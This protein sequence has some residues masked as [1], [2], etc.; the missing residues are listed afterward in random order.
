MAT[1]TYCM[2]SE[3]A[4]DSILLRPIGTASPRQ[5]EEVRSTMLSN[6]R[7]LYMTFT[8]ANFKET[9]LFK[10][11][12]NNTSMRDKQI[13]VI[14]STTNCNSEKHPVLQDTNTSIDTSLCIYVSYK[15]RKLIEIFIWIMQQ[16]PAM[17]FWG[18]WNGKL[19]IFL[20]NDIKDYD[21][22]YAAELF[23]LQWWW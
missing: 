7:S 21:L 20:D 23:T 3:C 6:I 19:G 22:Y 11:M 17:Y 14:W 8:T 2:H 10:T 4:W 13:A 16:L 1:C 15:F 9:G 18:Q 5:H 12:S